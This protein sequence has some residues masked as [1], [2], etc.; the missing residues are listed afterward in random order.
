MRWRNYSQILSEKSKLTE[1][2]DGSFLLYA[3]SRP[4]KI[5]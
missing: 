5:Y 3:K 1:V 2:L 4:I